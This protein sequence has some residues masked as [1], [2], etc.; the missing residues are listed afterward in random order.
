MPTA[1][2]LTLLTAV[3]LAA[4]AAG[5]AG[6]QW[7]AARCKL[8]LSDAAASCC[9]FCSGVFS[10]TTAAGADGQQLQDQHTTSLRDV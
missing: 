4:G 5:G 6:P 7:V 1:P 8:H 2:M 9:Y 10:H 3:L